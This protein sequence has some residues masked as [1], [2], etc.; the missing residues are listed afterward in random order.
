MSLS[1]LQDV[2][3]LSFEDALKE[4]ENIVRQLE[5]GQAKLEDAIAFYER[6]VHLKKRCEDLLANA[7]LTVEKITESKEGH[8]TSSPFNMDPTSENAS[9]SSKNPTD[10][11]LF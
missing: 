10:Q 4:L 6:G 7:H 3:D 11:P 9:S 2:Q 5:T 1:P 8:F